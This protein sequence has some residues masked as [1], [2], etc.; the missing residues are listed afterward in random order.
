MCYT[1]TISEQGGT[2][3]GG[4]LTTLTLESGL[5]AHLLYNW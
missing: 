1:S 4:A 3:R 2:G 5:L